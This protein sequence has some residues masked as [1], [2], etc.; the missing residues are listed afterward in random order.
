MK[1]IAAVPTVMM[2]PPKKLQPSNLLEDS[3]S[4]SAA[5]ETFCTK[6]LAV[7]LAGLV[8]DLK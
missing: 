4:E 5:E 8:A 7:S 3:K 1:A 6:G 2:I